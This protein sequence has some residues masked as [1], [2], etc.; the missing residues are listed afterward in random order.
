MPYGN[1]MG[2]GEGRP[3]ETSLFSGWYH[4]FTLVGILKVRAR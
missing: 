4:F 1:L 3:R 2:E